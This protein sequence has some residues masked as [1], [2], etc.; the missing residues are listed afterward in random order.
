MS[1]TK[2]LVKKI[3]GVLMSLV[4]MSTIVPWGMVKSLAAQNDELTFG[5]MSDIHYYPQSLMGSDV[6]EFIKAS[7]MNSSTSYLAD[8]VL[9][10]AFAEYAV[11][12]K[13][14]GLKYI[15]V[16]GDLTN[17]GELEG[18]KAMAQRFKEFE[19]TTGIQVIVINGNHDVRNTDA[20]AFNNGSFTKT[21]FTLPTEFRAIYADFG[22]DLADTFFTPPN[23]EE[24]G[25]LSYAATLDGG[26]RLIAL[27]GGRYSVDNTEKGKDEAEVGGNYSKALLDWAI[28][29]IK[30]AKAK[31][32]TVIGMTH[33][34][35]VPH[36]D[37]EDS[38]FTPFPIK[39]WQ[40]VCESF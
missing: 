21:Q 25:S 23:G 13:T 20:A 1:K 34:N 33:F 11:Q 18:H 29:Q 15:L 17:D 31:G 27:D 28:S 8:A 22:Y 16:P 3:I 14:K 7:K 10:S 35:L 9:D 30:D 40:E 24:A 4:L 38:L 19:D 2:R 36:F 12:A 37:S 6:N 5:V 32:L 39:N 26:Y